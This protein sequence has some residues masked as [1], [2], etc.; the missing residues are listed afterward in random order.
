MP[1]GRL[2]DLK[3]PCYVLPPTLRYL[4]GSG[5]RLNPQKTLLPFSRALCT[6]TV[7]ILLAAATWRV[8]QESQICTS[9]DKDL[10]LFQVLDVQQ[11]V[12]LP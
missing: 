8:P 1:G 11:D 3:D 12:Y 2:G 5:K 7:C 6:S 9:H 4:R 10:R